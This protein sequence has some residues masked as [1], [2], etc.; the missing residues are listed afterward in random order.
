MMNILD[1]RSRH[2]SAYNYSNRVY[3]YTAVG[4]YGL[5]NFMVNCIKNFNVLVS[6]ADRQCLPHSLLSS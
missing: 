4:I 6:F 3:M 1:C 2:L 5:F